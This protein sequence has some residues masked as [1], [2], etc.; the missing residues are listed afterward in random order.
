MRTGVV[1][2]AAGHAALIAVAIWGL[3]WLKPRQSEAVRVTE[4]SFVSEAEFAAAQ[5][6]A[7]AEA[8]RAAEAPPEPPRAA[9]PA[10]PEPAEAEVFRGP[11]AEEPPEEEAVAALAPQ[12]DPAAPLESPE[13]D[14][15]S[16]VPRVVTLSPPTAVTTP[17]PRPAPRIEATPTPPPPDEVRPAEVPE[18]EA[19]PEPEPAVVEEPRPPE[20]PPEAAPEPVAEPSP[21]ATLALLSSGRPKPRRRDAT[22]AAPAVAEERAP[23]PAEAAERQAAILE[24]VAAAAAGATP[25]TPPAVTAP[26]A[27][28]ATSLPVGP[29]LTTGE[30]DGLRL[31]VQRCWNVPAGLRDAQELTVVV[32]AELT[33]DG[34]VINAS[35]RLIEPSP[36]PDARFQQAY[37]AGRRALIRC[38]P[39]SDLP[40]D[41]FAQWRSIEVVFNPEGMLS[42]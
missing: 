10:E 42:W 1:I 5:A 7:S 3:P 13:P 2:S 22:P 25:P 19:A 12:F 17:R 6:A 21:P 30:K 27:A 29:P 35:I 15:P 41:K 38:S 39:Y 16:I 37:E 26:T 36:A 14:A 20:A 8:P 31:A 40:R 4:V 23:A 18:P 11:T 34:G 28:A 24:A 9:A 33:A 32:A